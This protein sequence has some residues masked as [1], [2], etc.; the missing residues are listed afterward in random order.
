MSELA[1]SI[2]DMSRTCADTSLLGSFSENHDNPR[3][4]SKNEDIALAKNVITFTMLT[5][6][7]PI[8]YQG[9][10]QHYRSLGG[11]DNP[12]NREAI[13]L[14]GYD[15]NHELYKL[16]TLLNRVRKHAMRED[17]T[18]LTTRAKVVHKSVQTIAIEKGGLL[19]VLS[20]GGSQSAKYIRSVR[21]RFPIGSRVTDILTCQT[22]M[23]G[24]NGSLDVTLEAGQP[25]VYYSSTRKEGLC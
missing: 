6:G 25:R 15:R 1:R 14:S 3:F 18:F 13:W 2:E 10:E 22:Q 21:S 24:R 17:S 7:I 23:V 5:D 12:Y 16:I 19:L 11:E 20:N 8:I 9:Q 4:P